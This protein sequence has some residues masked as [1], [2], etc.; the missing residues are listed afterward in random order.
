M[1]VLK[2]EWLKLVSVRTT[3]ALLGAMIFIEGLAAGLTTSLGDVAD[4]RKRSVATLIIGSQLAIVFM[5]TLGALLSTN[6]FRHGTAN[7]TFVVTP[8]RERVIAAK[9][10]VGLVVGIVGA[11]LYIAV[12][13][14]LGMSILSNRGVNVDAHEAVN[15]Y[16]GVGVGLV[17]GCLFGVAL[18][19]LLRNQILTVVTG[20]VIFLLAG[21][22]ALFIGNDVGQYF[23]GESLLAL[24]GTPGADK[25]LLTQTNGGLVLGAYCVVLGIAGMVF[26]RQREIT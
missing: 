20:M 19:A 17:L 24:Q 1:S 10:L 11:L 12:N 22:A 9:L 23:P 18:G 16:V 6:E 4:L 25:T 21:T 13:A 7:S 14:G 26:T 3:W 2:S 5:F 8:K 15:G